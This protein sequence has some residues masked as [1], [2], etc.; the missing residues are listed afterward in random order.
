MRARWLTAL[1]D[2]TVLLHVA[3]GGMSWRTE[4]EGTG[5]RKIDASAVLH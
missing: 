4:P 2:Q 1:R 3:D 5:G